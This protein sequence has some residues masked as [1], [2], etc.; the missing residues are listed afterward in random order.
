MDIKV[1]S[2]TF[3]ESEVSNNKRRADLYQKMVAIDPT[4]PT[5]EEHQ[6]GEIT[7]LR[8]MQF[9]ERE[10]SSA[11]LGFRIEAAKMPGGCLQKNF[12]KVKSGP[13]VTKSLID[14]FGNDRARVRSQLLARLKHMR[15]AIEKSKFFHEHEVGYL[16]GTETTVTFQVV[17]SSLLIVHDGEKVGCWMIDFAK[18]HHVTD[19]KMNHRST[20]IVGN[21]E[22]GYLTGMDNLIEVR[23]AET[24][25]TK[26]PIADTRRNAACRLFS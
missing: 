12:K 7:K 5:E 24:E 23:K 22:D 1:G 9:R 4:E 8:Y 15:T 17:G 18:S 10:S 25:R 13:D 11:Q 21:H 14:F 20:W 16:L 3:L 2:R 26:P 19:R 6:T